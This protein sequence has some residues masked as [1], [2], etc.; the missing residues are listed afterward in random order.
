M[1]ADATTYTRQVNAHGTVSYR[2]R[3]IGPQPY[4]VYLDLDAHGRAVLAPHRWQM[5]TLARLAR[6]CER[7]E[8]ER[9]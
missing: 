2:C 7:L 6:E 5:P 9:G 8:R 1:T 3:V 4:L